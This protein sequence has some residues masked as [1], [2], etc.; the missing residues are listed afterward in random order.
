MMMN[1]ICGLAASGQNRRMS[2]RTNLCTPADHK[3]V[4]FLARA[5]LQHLPVMLGLVH[6]RNGD[7]DSLAAGSRGCHTSL[8]QKFV[9]N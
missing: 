4:S 5:D 2:F 6:A 8:L 1:A 9:T 3:T 7:P